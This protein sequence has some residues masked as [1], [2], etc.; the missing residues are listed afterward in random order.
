MMK[1]NLLPTPRPLRLRDN[2]VLLMLTM[3]TSPEFWGNMLLLI[4]LGLMMWCR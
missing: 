4:G 2:A 1:I 3:A